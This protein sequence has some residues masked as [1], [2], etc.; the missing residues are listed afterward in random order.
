MSSFYFQGAPVA[1]VKEELAQEERKVPQ[2][3]KSTWSKCS[4]QKRAKK[5]MKNQ[6]RN[7][8][9]DLFPSKETHTACR[10]RQTNPQ[11]RSHEFFIEVGGWPDTSHQS[12]HVLGH[13]HSSTCL[14]QMSHAHP[15]TQWT[16]STD[17]SP[18]HG[19]HHTPQCAQSRSTYVPT[20]PKESHLG[21]TCKSIKDK[22]R[23][24]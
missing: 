8:K 6:I 14:Q 21:P 15:L 12:G 24:E 1:T 10:D 19:A 13:T 7:L 4:C 2:K 23:M 16:K 22:D 3:P 17:L 11:G 18:P 5:E 20:Y 9:I